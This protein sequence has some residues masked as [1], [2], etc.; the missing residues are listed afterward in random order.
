MAENNFVDIA[1]I[2]QVKD[3][4]AIMADRFTSIDLG[5]IVDK[6]MKKHELS[7][8]AM[9]DRSKL[10]K[11]TI[12]KILDNK[13]C[14]CLKTVMKISCLMGIHSFPSMTFTM[15]FSLLMTAIICDQDDFWR[16][17]YPL[18][19]RLTFEQYMTKEKKK[20]KPNMGR[21]PIPRTGGPMKDKSDYTRKDKHKKKIDTDTE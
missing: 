15:Q 12:R 1:Y 5:S 16:H 2:E 19:S 21:V 9:A 13:G 6:F 18:E 7:V 8:T 11:T 4:E 20:K 10:S 17:I 14:P 3:I